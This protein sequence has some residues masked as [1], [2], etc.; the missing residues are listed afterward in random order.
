M[1][2]KFTDK[3]MEI[4]FDGSITNEQKSS[5][6]SMTNSL[7]NSGEDIKIK[8]KS[9]FQE[10]GISQEKIEDTD[11]KNETFEINETFDNKNLAKFSLCH[12]CLKLCKCPIKESNKTTL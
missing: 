6:D 8:I 5:I 4:K 3:K 9:E 11:Q 10:I 1:R 12:P 7:N 2:D